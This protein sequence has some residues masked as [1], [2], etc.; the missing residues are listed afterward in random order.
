MNHL[1]PARAAAGFSIITFFFGAG[2]TLGPSVAGMVAKQ[3]GTFSS[4]YLLAA[5]A[6]GTTIFLAS[7]LRKPHRE[8][9]RTAR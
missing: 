8:D 6:T 4:S 9:P 5:A 3:T 7:T 1:G 2:Q